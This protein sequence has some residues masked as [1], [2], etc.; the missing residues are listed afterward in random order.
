MGKVIEL[1]SGDVN[2]WYNK[3][4]AYFLKGD[5][6]EFL[7]NLRKAITLDLEYKKG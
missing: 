7:E 1:Q 4:F 2:A 3:A 6:G 5:K